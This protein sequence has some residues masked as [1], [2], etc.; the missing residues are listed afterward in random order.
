[1]RSSAIWESEDRQKETSIRLSRTPQALARRL[2]IMANFWQVLN[3][4]LPSKFI[5]K[6]K[7][8]LITWHPMLSLFQVF[9]DLSSSRRSTCRPQVVLK[10]RNHKMA[11]VICRLMTSWRNACSTSIKSSQLGRSRLMNRSEKSTKIS[12]R[13]Q[14]QA[15]KLKANTRSQIHHSLKLDKFNH[16]L[17]AAFNNSN[18]L[19]DI[20]WMYT[21]LPSSST[22]ALPEKDKTPMERNSNSQ[23]S[24]PLKTSK[25]LTKSARSITRQS[26][27]PSHNSPSSHKSISKPQQLPD[28]L[29]SPLAWILSNRLQHSWYPPLLPLSSTLPQTKASSTTSSY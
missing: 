19:L 18:C 25:Y 12:S 11:A 1:M 4:R 14:H 26:N 17:E 20:T 28:Q 16:Q 21:S 13:E 22:T 7:R 5:L 24:P 8:S 10:S 3:S 23:I 15:R 29:Q 27:R 9:K 2:S 6:S